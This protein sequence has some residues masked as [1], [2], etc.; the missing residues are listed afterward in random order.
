MRRPT[1]SRRRRQ[2]P[3]RCPLGGEAG[4][5]VLEV[6]LAVTILV[7]VVSTAFVG[8]STALSAEAGA[9]AKGQATY[10]AGAAMSEIRQEVISANILFDPQDEFN[11]TGG[12]NGTTGT[13]CAVPTTTKIGGTGINCAGINADGTAIAPGFSLR[14]YTQENGLLTCVQWR[15]L[16]TGTLQTRSWSDQWQ[17]NG[18]VH[19]WTNLVTGL[20]NKSS[21]PPF[22]LDSDS[23]YGGSASSR[24]LDIDLVT[25]SSGDPGG[26]VAVQSSI[27]GRDAEY[28]PSNTGDCSPVPPA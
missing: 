6:A 27:A 12:Y 9:D 11:S 10:E 7:G 16:D 2:R 17:V 21:V 8:L 22:V 3:P 14:I 24:L 15:V 25:V 28:Y 26:P 5:T 1:Q 19:A 4:Q 23:N 18:I 20:T 13:N